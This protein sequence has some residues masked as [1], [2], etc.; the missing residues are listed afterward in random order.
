MHML[1][2]VYSSYIT[3]T[4]THTL[5]IRAPVSVINT[6][7]CFSQQERKVKFEPGPYCSPQ[8]DSE[9]V[10]NLVCTLWRCA[11]LCQ[12][13]TDSGHLSTNLQQCKSISNNIIILTDLKLHLYIYLHMYM[14]LT[15]SPR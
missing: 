7:M 2:H 8:F 4:H 13:I 9:D 5:I 14:A 11:A 15:S 3:H 6:C 1:H 12:Q 10:C